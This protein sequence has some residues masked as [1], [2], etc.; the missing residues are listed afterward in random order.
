[1]LSGTPTNADVGEHLVEL[2]V[3]EN[4]P[5]P[6]L[7]GIQQFTVT[8]VPAIVIG[9][10]PPLVAGGGGSVGSLSVLALLLFFRG[11]CRSCRRDTVGIVKGL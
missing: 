6:G 10:P 7:S 4:A 11:R 9:D 2:E 3:R 1:M 5:A 8:V